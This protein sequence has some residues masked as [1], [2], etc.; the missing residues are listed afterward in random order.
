M[1]MVYK[2][3][4][5][6]PLHL[7][8]AHAKVSFETKSRAQTKSNTAAAIAVAVTSMEVTQQK[9]FI[10]QTKMNHVNTFSN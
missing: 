3:Q 6:R 4:D 8:Q 2:Q 9:Q 7:F 10:E 1:S 5:H